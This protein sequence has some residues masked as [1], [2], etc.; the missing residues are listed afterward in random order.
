MLKKIIQLKKKIIHFTVTSKG[1]K[2][3]EGYKNYMCFSACIESKA[4]LLALARY[5]N[6]LP[7]QHLYN[8]MMETKMN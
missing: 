7:L 2:I 3:Y 4:P 8:S 6:T 5:S 1:C